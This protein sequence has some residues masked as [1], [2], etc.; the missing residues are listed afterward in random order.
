MS[1]FRCNECDRDFSGQQALEDHNRSK[2]YVTPKK[3]SGKRVKN[4]YIWILLIIAIVSSVIGVFGA[5]KQTR[6]KRLL[7]YSSIFH[8]GILIL[9]VSGTTIFNLSKKR[10]AITRSNAISTLGMLRW[11]IQVPFCILK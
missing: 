2:H 10:V 1:E 9:S 6:L 11:M 3:Q 4:R 8:S 7:A 5:L